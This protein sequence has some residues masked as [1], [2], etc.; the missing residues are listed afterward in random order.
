MAMMLAVVAIAGCSSDPVS[1]GGDDHRSYTY[2]YLRDYQY[3]PRTYYDVGKFGADSLGIGFTTGQDSIIGF[4]LFVE[5]SA[6][7]PGDIFAVIAIDPRDLGAYPKNIFASYMH[8]L[9]EGI[10]YFLDPRLFRLRFHEPLPSD[11]VLA[12]WMWVATPQGEFQIGAVDPRPGESR[13]LKMLKAAIPYPGSPTWEY[14]WLNVY[15]LGVTGFTA[16][17]IKVD[18]FY[19]PP[20]TE[21]DS[22]NLDDQAGVPLIQLLGLDIYD[23]DGVRSPD[24]KLDVIDGI[25]DPANGHLL[26]PNRRPFAPRPDTAYCVSHPEMRLAATFPALYTTANTIFIR[27]ES[28]YYLRI[29]VA[30]DGPGT[31]P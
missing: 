10:D 3:L 13:V 23:E 26:F 17:E 16:G 4:K 8:E 28:I 12:C 2:T 11:E 31:A 5:G 21:E 20:G 18:V 9:D 22:V 24:G 30:D 19:G 15:D 14:Q 6:E 1:S 29:G 7:T 27:D 25:V